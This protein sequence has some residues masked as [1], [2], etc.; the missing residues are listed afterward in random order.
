MQ[1]S[2]RRA[3]PMALIGPASQRIARHHRLASHLPVNPTARH[4]A[5]LTASPLGVRRPEAGA[6]C[7]KG[8][9]HR[10]AGIAS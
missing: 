3:A 9:G 7:G 2:A 4:T 5:C 8:G 1:R 10:S 6:R